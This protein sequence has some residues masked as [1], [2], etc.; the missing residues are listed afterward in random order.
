LLLSIWVLLAP[1]RVAELAHIDSDVITGIV[2]VDL[3][4]VGPVP[5]S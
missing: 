3:G 5:R 4:A 2:A 1:S